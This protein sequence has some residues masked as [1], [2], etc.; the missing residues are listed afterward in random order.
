MPPAIAEQR[1][2]RVQDEAKSKGRPAANAALALAA[3]NIAITNVPRRMLSL[4]DALVLM[5][6]RWQIELL[7]KLWKSHGQVDTWRTTNP[8][9]ILCEVYAKL[10]G[11][12]FQQWI[13]AASSW[14]DPERSFVK[15]AQ[16]VATS[17]ADLASAM[18]CAAQ[19]ERVLTRLA[20]VIQRLARMQKRQ[21]PPTTAQLLLVAEALQK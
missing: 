17:A 9:R 11:L 21:N 7:F 12:V 8:A 2:R 15:A 14:T 13:L 3:W 10:I 6:I 1:R 19:V 5:R 20:R 4:A 18:G 16:F